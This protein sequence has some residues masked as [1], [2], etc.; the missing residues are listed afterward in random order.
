MKSSKLPLDP[1]LEQFD[2]I[3][4]LAL[5]PVVPDRRIDLATD[6][7]EQLA[8]FALTRFA[9]S[10]SLELVRPLVTP[11]LRWL[12][13]GL[14]HLLQGS[15]PLHLKMNRCVLPGES[16]SIPGLGLEA[17]SAL[18]SEIDPDRFIIWSR[19]AERGLIRLGSLDRAEV[20]PKGRRYARYLQS[21]R[22]LARNDPDRPIQR[23][24]AFLE[25]VA[26]LRGR[27]LANGFPGAAAPEAIRELIRQLR[28]RRPLRAR[29][30]QRSDKTEPP[31]STW[32]ERSR[33]AWAILS[34]GFE[35]APLS[36]ETG[37][38]FQLV[39][40]AFLERFR[41]HP[42]ECD[43]LWQAV[44]DRGAA[45]AERKNDFR[46]D[47]FARDTFRFLSEL[48]SNNRSGWMA[49]RRDRYHF[50]VRDPL[51]ELGHHLTE[52]YVEPVLRK[53]M[54]WDL[55]TEPR[56]GKSLSSVVK[57]DYGQSVPYHTTMWLT[58]YRSQPRGRR[59]DV[60][61]FVR[62]DASGV[63]FG[64]QLGKQARD[65]GHR[66]R[67]NVQAHAE[68]LYRNLVLSGSLADC[69]FRHDSGEP[70]PIRDA[71]GLREWA[72]G[73]VLV[74]ER[75]LPRESP[76]LLQDDL[77]G[78]I[79]LTW[80]RLLPLFC[81]AMEPEPKDWL[82]RRLGSLSGEIDFDR[83]AFRRESHLPASWL[84]RALELL[85]L[86]KQL[87]LQG[88]PG[89]GKTHVAKL[90]ARLLT[91]DR[92]EQ[93]RVVQFHPSYCYEEFVEGIKARTVEV[94]GKTEVAYP[95]ENGVLLDFAERAEREPSKP[96]VLL[97]D[98]INRGNL[99]RIFGELLYLLEYRQQA[100]SLPY[101]RQLFRLPA[102]LYLIGT[103]NASDRSVAQLDQALR[104]RFSFLEMPPDPRVLIHWFERHPS[105]DGE[106]FARQVVLLFE[107]L[108]EKLIQDLGPSHQIGHSYFMVPNLD[109]A[110]LRMVWDHHVRPQLIESFGGNVGRADEYDLEKLMRGRKRKTSE[111]E[112][113]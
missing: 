27:D 93:T 47:G 62:L 5:S 91:H 44:L 21:L 100:V 99:P 12:R 11:H 19:P 105:R 37:A 38:A 30:E 22:K 4:P 14:D 23:W 81:A 67:A 69:Q 31:V 59:D 3:R 48:E 52:R 54:G 94:N 106:L 6:S 51:R 74:G 109:E 49:S 45:D 43:D 80:D 41:V 103:M 56:T 87:I 58:Y 60:Q 90:L 46:F 20:Q 64:F 29:L 17:W 53:G 39:V 13:F 63:R 9:A 112:G 35:D 18:L 102:N 72:A 104:R 78:E 85:Q 88:V 32:D 83:D 25:A 42:L 26:S 86:K 15:D 71:G 8:D 70:I 96:H 75:S 108:N 36:P 28:V 68:L 84:D 89:T 61:W 33:R 10:F 24:I 34:D 2:S 101:S 113:A 97:I 76:L 110:K 57:N 79:I 1:L 65:A 98:E 55:E 7:D 40:A 82:T 73:K 77:V 107:A 16:Y 66:F 92:P 95:V 50:V 111:T